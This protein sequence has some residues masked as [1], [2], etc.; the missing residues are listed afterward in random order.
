VLAGASDRTR[1]VSASRRKS[2]CKRVVPHDMKSMSATRSKSESIAGRINTARMVSPG[3]SPGLRAVRASHIPNQPVARISA[4]ILTVRKMAPRPPAR[5]RGRPLGDGAM[6]PTAVGSEGKTKAIHDSARKII[7]GQRKILSTA[8]HCALIRSGLRK[9]V[10]SSSSSAPLRRASTKNH[11]S[12]R[13][14]RK[15]DRSIPRNERRAV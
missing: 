6:E 8:R 15:P 10:Q 9:V 2:S 1:V 11:A 12:G 5:I 7:S 4:P 3:A 13:S 14:W